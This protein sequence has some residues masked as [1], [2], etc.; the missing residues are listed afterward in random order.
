[1]GRQYLISTRP[2]GGRTRLAGD[3][4]GEIIDVQGE[5]G[6]VAV[7]VAVDQDGERLA[8]LDLQ[9]GFLADLAARAVGRVLAGIEETAG[10]V[11]VALER[12]DRPRGE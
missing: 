9:A 10:H 3:D 4:A 11:P 6:P 1:L 2:G 7:G 12:L 5:I 8:E